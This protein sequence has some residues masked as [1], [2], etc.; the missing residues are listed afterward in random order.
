[1]KIEII[2]AKREILLTLFQ[3]GFKG[4]EVQQWQSRTM[5][6]TITTTIQECKQVAIA[7]NQILLVVRW[8]NKPTMLAKIRKI[9]ATTTKITRQNH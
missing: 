6:S 3:T 2:L 4:K 7:C 8:Q 5:P 1:M 9:K